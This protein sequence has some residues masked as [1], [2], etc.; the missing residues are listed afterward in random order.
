MPPLSAR[1]VQGRVGGAQGTITHQD[2]DNGARGTAAR[3]FKTS[4]LLRA[5]DALFS[6]VFL[7]L[8]LWCAQSRGAVTGD[9][10]P[11][12]ERWVR[13]TPNGR[14][15]ATHP[16]A[17]LIHVARTAPSPRPV[18]IRTSGPLADINCVARGAPP[19]KVPWAC[20][21][22]AGL[23]WGTVL[24]QWRLWASRF[25]SPDRCGHRTAQWAGR[26]QPALRFLFTACVERASS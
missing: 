16:T 9:R 7:S 13:P 26:G 4:L 11:R 19:R 18:I 23:H 2:G 5:T 15:A 8:V 14:C 21:G 22:G 10:D 24:P 3:H 20:G 6:S 17:L 12:L 1:E 25:E